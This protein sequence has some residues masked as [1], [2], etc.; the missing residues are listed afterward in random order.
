MCGSVKE[1]GQGRAL[2]ITIRGASAS[3]LGFRC[4]PFRA[5]LLVIPTSAR[6]PAVQPTFV[7]GCTDGRSGRDS[8][9]A[10][11]KVSVVDNYFGTR[12]ADP[13][14]WFEVESAETKR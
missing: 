10:A 12:V 6:K 2:K 4:P 11:R 3:N 1:N 14:R 8:L 7:I 13:N 9:P 5:R